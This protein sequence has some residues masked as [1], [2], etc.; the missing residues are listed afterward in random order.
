MNGTN[1]L[2]TVHQISEVLELALPL[3]FLFEYYM[4][5]NAQSGLVS[6]PQHFHH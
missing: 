2:F 3:P 1:M 4:V 5:S 6:T